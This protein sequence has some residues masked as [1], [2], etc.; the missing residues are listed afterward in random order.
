MF[1]LRKGGIVAAFASLATSILAQDHSSE[2]SEA[3]ITGLNHPIVP[4]LSLYL[5]P[6]RHYD[7]S[8]H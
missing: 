1:V 5:T 3:Q 6:T 8:D 4:A 7:R 2:Q